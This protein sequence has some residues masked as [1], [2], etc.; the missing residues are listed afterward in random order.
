MIPGQID[1]TPI[2]QRELDVRGVHGYAYDDWEEQRL[3]TIERCI[4]W[5]SSGRLATG[6]LLTHRFPIERNRDAITTA[7]SHH[8]KNSRKAQRKKA[9]KVAFDFG[10]VHK[11]WHRRHRIIPTGLPFDVPLPPTLDDGGLA[12]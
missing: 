2:W 7:T 1:F 4:Q 6:G 8:T 3:H 10:L 9:V 5:I 12:T 11:A